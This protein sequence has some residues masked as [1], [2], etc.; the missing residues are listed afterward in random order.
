MSRYFPEL[1][2]HSGENV[3]VELD[4]LNY[5]TKADLKVATSIDQKQILL[6]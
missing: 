6:A 3:K 2:E 1:H 4:L 5:P